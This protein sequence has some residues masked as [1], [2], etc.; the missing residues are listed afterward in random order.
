VVAQH[1]MIMGST[2]HGDV[3]ISYLADT[4]LLFRYF[5]AQGEI[6]Q[7]ISVF[8]KRTGSHERTI[9]QLTIDTKGVQVGEPLREFRGIMTGVPM[10]QSS[11]GGELPGLRLRERER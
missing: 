9:R 8:K 7:A 3:D 5:E 4:V 10:Y 2:L 6:H 1:G 11:G